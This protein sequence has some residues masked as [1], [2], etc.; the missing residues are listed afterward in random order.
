[1]I[2]GLHGFA[3]TGKVDTA[4]VLARDHG[5]DRYSLAT[6]IRDSLMAMNPLIGQRVFL[7]DQVEQS[8]WDYVK[9]HPVYSSQVRRLMVTFGASIKSQFGQDLLIEHLRQRLAENHG[10]MIPA[11]ARIVISD[12]RLPDEAEFVRSLGGQVVRLEVPGVGPGSS[13]P[14]ERPLPD[15]LVDLTVQAS[16]DPDEVASNL[17]H[18]LG[19]ITVSVAPAMDAALMSRAVNDDLA[20]LFPFPGN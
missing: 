15:H 19:L 12:V 13:D 4:T 18:K 7:R 9:N 10:V 6:P 16:R 11:S 17:A 20:E 1:M 8:G 2:V 3:G 5:F 14:T